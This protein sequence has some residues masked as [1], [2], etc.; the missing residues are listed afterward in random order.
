[1]NDYIAKPFDPDEL[2]AKICKYAG[3]KI[4][5][6]PKITTK[7]TAGK[8]DDNSFDFS[9]LIDV[10]S[11]DVNEVMNV[12]NVYAEYVPADIKELSNA[13]ASD[14]TEQIRMKLHS[15]KTAFGYMG[16]TSASELVQAVEDE[17]NKENGQDTNAIISELTELWNS[18]LPKIQ[19][20]IHELQVSEKTNS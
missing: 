10:C 15:L 3:L 8:S 7:N 4:E 13:I 5:L 9:P 11:E 12:V 1:M 19:N 17:L 18:T 14:N 20:R 16:M 2:F 6:Q